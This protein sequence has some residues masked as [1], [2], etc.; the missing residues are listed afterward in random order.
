MNSGKKLSSL[1]KYTIPK[2]FNI[3]DEKKKPE[4][5]KKIISS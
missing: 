5:V 3:T 4:A 2:P 1:E